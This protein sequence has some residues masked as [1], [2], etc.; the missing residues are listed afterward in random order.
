MENRQMEGKATNQ[1]DRLLQG[2]RPERFE[3]AALQFKDQRQVFSVHAGETPFLSFRALDETG[4]VQNSFSTRF[5]GVSEGYLSSL[6]FSFAKEGE[7]RARVMENYCRMA[8]AMEVDASRMVLSWQTHTTNV[9]LVTEADCGKGIFRP[10][11][12]QDVDGLI[13]NT[14]GITLVTLSADCVPLYILDPI[15]KAIGLSH[16]GWRGTVKRMGAATI[17][18][19]QEAFGSDPADLICCIGPSICRDCFEVGGEVA[20]AFLE[21][22]GEA[23]RELITKDG[24]LLNEAALSHLRE[25]EEAALC[26]EKYH[27]DLWQANVQVFLEA[28]VP[29]KQVIVTNLCTKC[30]SA[31]L[32]SHRAFGTRRGNLAGFL[33]LR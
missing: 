9:R 2:Q 27:V 7:Q 1:A 20:A 25:T 32:W 3:P 21:S 18:R 31:Q 17:A 19:M 24:V 23:A 6:N 13:C 10:R 8:K 30:N 29:K 28:G 15:H 14:P 11:D 26:R 4:L 22:F 16:S 5:G 12:Y 33:C